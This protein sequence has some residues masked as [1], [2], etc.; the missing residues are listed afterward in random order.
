[1]KHVISTIRLANPNRGHGHFP[2]SFGS[3]HEY[4]IHRRS[5]DYC[6]L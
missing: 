6:A 3:S 2:H 4:R 1:M 5:E